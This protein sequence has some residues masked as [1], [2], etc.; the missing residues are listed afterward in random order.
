M[1]KFTWIMISIVLVSAIGMTVYFQG[2]FT[3]NA[4]KEIQPEEGNVV[5]VG[6]KGNRY[7]D[8]TVTA[9]QPTILRNDGTLRGCSTFIVQRELG[10]KADLSSGDYEFTPTKK[11]TFISTCSMG[12]YT[13][14]I[15]VI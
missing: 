14:T 12:M 10:I 7:T 13:G 1:D 5:L 9:N 2:P 11:G 6:V 15:K 3:G 4:V 8:I